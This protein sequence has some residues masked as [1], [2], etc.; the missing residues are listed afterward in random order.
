MEFDAVNKYNRLISNTVI[1]AIG[2]FSSKVLVFLLLPLYTSVL[3][4]EALGAGDLVRNTANLLIPVVSVSISGAVIR[5]G[6]DKSYRKTEVFTAGVA[7]VMLGL[8]L[9]VFLLPLIGLVQELGNYLLLTYLY[10]MMSVLRTLCAQFVRSR[11]LVRFYAIDGIFST[12]MT[13]LFNV[14]FLLV[15]QWGVTGYLMATIC[16]D[17]CSTL[18]LFILGG[19][20]RYLKF[21]RLN[22]NVWSQMLRF[23]IPMVPSSVFWWITTASDRYMIV[24]MMEDGLAVSGLYTV[25][26]KLPNIIMIVGS[27]FSDAWQM[28]AIGERESGGRAEFYS[29]VFRNYQSLVLFA[30]SGIIAFCRL[31]LPILAPN[32]EYAGSWQYVPLLVLSTAF[33]IFGTFFSSIFQA[34]K[35]TGTILMTTISG[36]AANVLLNYLMIPV[37]GANGAALATFIS[38]FIVFSLRALLSQKYVA[39]DLCGLTLAAAMVLL[40]GQTAVVVFEAPLW[41]LWTGLLLLAVFVLYA[42]ELLHMLGLILRRLCKG[43]RKAA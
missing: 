19:L 17:A 35:K 12:V 14:L 11:G 26:Q 15:F 32:P 4:P 6:L 24:Y 18:F 5:F 16:A 29:T 41:P 25:A 9:L 22:L 21:S 10:I 30:S 38:H 34:E 8:I 37:L 27:I 1:F 36:A 31:V 7:T 2:T 39:V 23:S 3:S 40:L 42:R 33:T 43:V 13:I 28:S 20:G